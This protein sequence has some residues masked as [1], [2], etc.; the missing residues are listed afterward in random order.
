MPNRE[1][2][3]ATVGLIARSLGV[4]VSRVQ[5]IVLTRGIRPAARAGTLRLFDTA[6][7]RQ[8]EEALNCMRTRGGA[9][10]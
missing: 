9:R 1:P 6:A 10:R 3:L 4:P 8:I 2:Q 7:E 5:Y